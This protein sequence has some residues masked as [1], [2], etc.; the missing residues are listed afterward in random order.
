MI[1]PDIPDIP[2]T[3]P[4]SP[5]SDR[6]ARQ[7]DYS[8]SVRAPSRAS[9]RQQEYAQP[10][11]DRPPSRAVS[12]APSQRGSGYVAPE[13]VHER[14]SS[15]AAS[16]HAPSVREAAYEGP[17]AT[18]DR[19]PSRAASVRDVD[20]RDYARPASRAA[21]AVRDFGDNPY[22][23]ASRAASVAPAQD[24]GYPRAPSRASIA[25][26]TRGGLGGGGYADPTT[27][28]LPFSTAPSFAP[29]PAESTYRGQA[30]RYQ[31]P[32]AVNYPLPPSEDRTQY[33]RTPGRGYDDL[34]N[35][36]D[37]PTIVRPA[38]RAPT[39]AGSQ[40]ASPTPPQRPM[41]P[42]VGGG[43]DLPGR[44]VSRA[45]SMRA[46]GTTQSYYAQLPALPM[47]GGTEWGSPED[48]PQ[49][50]PLSRA[51][52]YKPPGTSR[53]AYP[54]LPDEGETN[55]GS[56]TETVRGRPSSRASFVPPGMAAK[57]PY[58]DA[59]PLSPDEGGVRR[60][61]SH[62][63]MR[64]AFRDNNP[65]ANEVDMAYLANGRHESVLRD[66]ASISRPASRAASVRSAMRK[67]PRF[68]GVEIEEDRDLV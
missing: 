43:L 33:G 10:V 12:M 44:S 51:A 37:Q 17:A 38:S 9:V 68:A 49:Q 22:R 63:S 11:Y 67:T 31:T 24:D 26:S 45:Q 14:P 19:S 28:P 46:P 64:S 1:A 16:F 52:S 56:P 35:A 34:P 13:P 62:V 55:W 5:A 59:A 7:V 30:S 42:M 4:P 29:L 20:A 39:Q 27:I 61:R 66:P 3:A 53:T 40:V 50:R 32:S 47:G 8:G 57:S 48:T 41:G 54:A 6:T 21:T 2:N 58:Y 65:A 23:S 25:R 15:R 36:Y 18:Y 60:S